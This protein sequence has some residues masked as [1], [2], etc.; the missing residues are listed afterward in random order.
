MQFLDESTYTQED[1]DGDRLKLEEIEQ[2]MQDLQTKMSAIYAETSA[3]GEPLPSV[4]QELEDA[5]N[6]LGIEKIILQMQVDTFNDQLQASKPES[7]REYSES[8]LQA[9][10]LNR[11]MKDN[12]I[13][14]NKAPLS[15]G[16]SIFSL[17][18]DK[19][20]VGFAVYWD[21]MLDSVEDVLPQKVT[22][23]IGSFQSA[24]F[25]IPQGNPFLNNTLLGRVEFVVRSGDSLLRAL[26]AKM[27]YDIFNPRVEGYEM[28]PGDQMRAIRRQVGS[29]EQVITINPK[30]AAVFTE[31]QSYK[32]TCRYN[33]KGRTLFKADVENLGL[34]QTAI[35]DLK[36]SLL[37]EVE[38]FLAPSIRYAIKLANDYES[39]EDVI[40]FSMQMQSNAA[41]FTESAIEDLTHDACIKKH[42]QAFLY[43]L[44]ERLLNA[45]YN[46]R[47]NI[48]DFTKAILSEEL[49]VHSVISNALR[50]VFPEYNADKISAYANAAI[51]MISNCDESA[52]D[53]V[54]CRMS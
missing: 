40:M 54:T 39:C 41:E 15:V 18:A 8:Y 2:K 14:L 33:K 27:D 32:I 31:G 48:G 44:D 38:S 24:E 26:N 49:Q 9:Q 1:Y 53:V 29:D 37:P 7:E 4:Y 28:L 30:H 51:T 25:L 43:G 13:E 11:Q 16:K 35:I 19:V 3:K 47:D 10:E 46:S 17:N 21:G 5:H 12:V 20:R 22:L 34:A 52:E 45:I 36:E 23:Q 50:E 42:I 6:E